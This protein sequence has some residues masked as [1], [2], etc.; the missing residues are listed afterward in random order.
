MT[1]K[2]L[3]YSGPGASRTVVKSLFLVLATAAV[4][5]VLLSILLVE[6]RQVFYGVVLAVLA[7]LVAQ[8]ISAWITSSRFAP[9]LIEAE[10]Q[11][12]DGIGDL[13]R[14]FSLY[15]TGHMAAVALLFGPVAFITA[16]SALGL[17]PARL[18]QSS[19]VIT[20]VVQTLLLFPVWGMSRVGFQQWMIAQKI[21]HK[22]PTHFRSINTMLLPIVAIPAVMTA[23]GFCVAGEIIVKR[24]AEQL[25]I[26][27]YHRAAAAALVETSA[28]SGVDTLYDLTRFDRVIPFAYNQ[29]SGDQRGIDSADLR[30]LN[31]INRGSASGTTIN[32]E[33]RAGL[34]WV[35][36]GGSDVIGGIRVGLER[37][38]IASYYQQF[39]VIIASILASLLVAL[40]Y[41]AWLRRPLAFTLESIDGLP[42][43]PVPEIDLGLPSEVLGLHSELEKLERRFAVMREAQREAIEGGRSAREMK[44]QFFAGISHELRSPLN[45][46]IGFTDLLLKGLEGPLTEKQQHRVLNIAE[47]AEKLMVL[48]ADILDTSKLDAG[49]FEVD[50]AWV[51]AADL[52]TE[53][54]SEAR[55]LVGTRPITL[56]INYQADLPLVYVDKARIRQAFISLLAQVLGAI[57]EGQVGI[58]A[59]LDRDARAGETFLRVEI[60]DL[61]GTVSAAE[62][63]RIKTVFYYVEGTPAYSSAG[64]LG[65]GIALA[66]DVVRLHG[67]EL[68]L[69]ANPGIGP[70]F[71]MRLPFEGSIDNE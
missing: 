31:K 18:L 23:V 53:C 10:K 41:G 45:S 27:A 28:E 1:D 67:G 35:S 50:R 9:Q 63:A 33:N 44:A 52:L 42:D 61:A 25:T 15:M 11:G 58:Q 55:R 12:P 4:E 39:A 32:S 37:F 6:D 36:F 68:E 71:T 34:A 14:T 16:S 38:S 54:T 5:S 49:T 57:E 46:V 62:I 24:A 59:T 48:I 21:V 13:L 26:E 2:A 40:W 22:E 3:P 29:G 7:V 66:R 8:L 51:P 56:D 20:F 43:R 64:G 65:L 70:I 30:M 19:G 60:V 69:V 17:G 47:E